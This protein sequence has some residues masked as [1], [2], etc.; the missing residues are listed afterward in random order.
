MNNSSLS[1]SERQEH[2]GIVN[3]FTPDPPERQESG[4]KPPPSQG[5]M[6]KNFESPRP[7]PRFHPKPIEVPNSYSGPLPRAPP[8]NFVSNHCQL[9]SPVSFPTPK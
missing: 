6:T 1:C 8:Y 9:L 4:I 7:C 3:P 2:V 5:P